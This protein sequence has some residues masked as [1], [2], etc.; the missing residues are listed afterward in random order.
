MKNIKVTVLCVSCMEEETDKD[1]LIERII[2]MRI[3]GPLY[4]NSETKTQSQHYK[5]S[6]CNKMIS[7]HID[8]LPW[9]SLNVHVEKDHADGV[10]IIGLKTN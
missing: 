1:D 4:F 10:C 6:I 5:C 9:K 3:E 7:V 2:E 8:I